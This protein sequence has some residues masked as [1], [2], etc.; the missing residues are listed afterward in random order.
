MPSRIHN[1]EGS[2]SRKRLAKVTGDD[3]GDFSTTSIQEPDFKWPCISNDLLEHCLR[4]FFAIAAHQSS[5]FVGF[6]SP[7]VAAAAAT[8]SFV[9]P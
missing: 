9:R 2:L 7:P 3:F 4:I 6:P 8:P 5:W 1:L